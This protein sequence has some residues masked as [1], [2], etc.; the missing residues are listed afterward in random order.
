[1]NTIRREIEKSVKLI[2]II[3]KTVKAIE[4]EYLNLSFH[5]PPKAF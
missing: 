2:T 1:M 4:N 5:W 3:P